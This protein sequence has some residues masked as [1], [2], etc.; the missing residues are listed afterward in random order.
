MAKVL[1]LLPICLLLILI[2]FN[3]K[4]QPLSWSSR[5]VG[6]GGALFSCAINPANASEY[7][8]SCDMGELFHTVNAGASYNQVH[9]NQLIGGHNSKVCFTI[10]PGLLYSISYENN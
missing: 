10:T 6:G 1:R 7:Y 5:G 2:T 3:S 4:G 8:V 9:F